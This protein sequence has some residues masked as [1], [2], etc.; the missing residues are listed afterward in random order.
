MDVV[1]EIVERLPGS[2]F[3][4]QHE[5]VSGRDHQW[6]QYLRQVLKVT[7]TLQFA[8]IQRLNAEVFAS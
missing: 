8:Q 7:D 2:Y 3:E 4:L 5:L 1:Q 6:H